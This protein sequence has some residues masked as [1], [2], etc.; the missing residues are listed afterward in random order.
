MRP[1]KFPKMF[2]TNSTNVWKSSEYIKS[3]SQNTALLLATERGEQIGDPYIGCKLQS[4]LFSQNNYILDD[5]LIDNIYTQIALFIPQIKV[6]RTD[7]KI[8]RDNKKG[9]VYCQI[10]GRSQI[11]YTL[12]TYNLLLFD[13]SE[14]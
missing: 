5:I 14:A 8:I 12:N 6:K 9:K 3:T 7:I 11:D 10:T 13:Q 4:L 1:I 2:N